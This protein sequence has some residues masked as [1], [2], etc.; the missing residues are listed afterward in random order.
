MLPAI[1]MVYLAAMGSIYL[2]FPGMRGYSA[3]V[4]EK[5]PLFW[6]LTGG[7]VI[8]L[9]LILGEGVLVGAHTLSPKGYFASNTWTERFCLAYLLL[10]WISALASPWFPETVGGVSRHEGAL[11][12]TL[13][14]LAF[15][16]VVRWGRAKPLLLWIWA[17]SLSLCCLL[18][19]PVS[20]TVRGIGCTWRAAARALSAAR[21][22]DLLSGLNRCR[23]LVF[24]PPY[25]QE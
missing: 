5:Y 8:A 23:E 12:I 16:L 4:S 24:A 3:I 13:S 9:V 14:C 2:L 10:T 25:V 18:R 7:Y 20:V 22:C 15:L 17:G 6:I 21:Y 11:T 1:T 19:C